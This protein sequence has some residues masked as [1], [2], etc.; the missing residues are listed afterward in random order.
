[1]F[2]EKIPNKYRY[3][4][5]CECLVIWTNDLIVF[6]NSYRDLFA[7]S[8]SDRLIYLRRFATTGAD[9]KLVATM[10]G[11]VSEVVQVRAQHV[12]TENNTCFQ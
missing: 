2:C 10:S 7:Y 4:I 1:M 3:S 9:M 8:S 5:T 11:H 12:D 6:P